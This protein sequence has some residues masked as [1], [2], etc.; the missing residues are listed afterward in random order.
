M[1]ILSETFITPTD[2]S[3]SS[4]QFLS[5]KVSD[6]VRKSKNNPS[7]CFCLRRE[8][9]SGRGSMEFSLK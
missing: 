9:T 1:T 7:S 6:S 8:I 4:F 2:F 3:H 5:S